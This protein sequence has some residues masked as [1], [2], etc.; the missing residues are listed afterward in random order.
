[1]A[2]QPARTD[3]VGAARAATD[4]G[5]FRWRKSSASSA[6]RSRMPWRW[7]SRI[8]SACRCARRASSSS[9]PT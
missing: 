8:C 7:C 5:K 4:R 6:R 1:V 9:A 3:A 2:G